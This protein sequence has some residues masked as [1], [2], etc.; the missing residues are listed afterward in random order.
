MYGNRADQMNLCKQ[1]PNF[2][3]ALHTRCQLLGRGKRIVNDQYL[4]I[5]D[6]Q[7]R[8]RNR[9]TAFWFR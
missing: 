6:R 1:A 9:R 3:M 7:S 8:A 4:R 5:A 2:Q